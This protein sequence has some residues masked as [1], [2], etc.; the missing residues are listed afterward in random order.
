MLHAAEADRSS[1]LALAASD[2]DTF[3][4][5]H[6]ARR[7]APALTDFRLFWTKLAQALAGKSKVILDDEPGRRRHL[8]MPGLALE[9]ALPVLRD[10]WPRSSQR[11]I[12]RQRS[13]REPLPLPYSRKSRAHEIRI[14]AG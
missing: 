13:G 4:S 7:Y 10:D 3:N 8:I 14:T 9:R 12:A 1:R 2:A 11:S 5:L 6:D